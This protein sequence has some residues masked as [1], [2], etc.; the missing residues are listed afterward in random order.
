M[1]WKAVWHYQIIDFGSPVADLDR[2]LERL[3]IKVPV[4][5][6]KLRVLLDNR[7]NEECLQLARIAAR[8]RN[9]GSEN[10]MTD[11][12]V[13]GRQNVE[14][15][16]G[17]TVFSDAVNVAVSAGDEL[18]I[19]LWIQHAKRVRGLC[20]TWCARNWHSAFSRWQSTEDQGDDWITSTALIPWLRED[21][22]VPN[23]SVGLSQVE[24]LTDDTVKTIAL[25]GDSITHMS[26]YSDALAERLARDYPG[27]AVI[28]NAG[29]GG[30]RLCYDASFSPDL[31]E[32]SSVFGPAGYRRFEHDTFGLIHPDTVLMLEGVNDITHGFQYERLDQ[33]PSAEFFCERYAEVIDCAHRNG[34]RIWVGTI[35]PE[36]V[37]RS[38]DWYALSE[39]LRIEIN[40]WIRH[41]HLADG[42][43]DFA[44]IA[45]SGSGRL[46]DGF[47]LDGLH[48]N[49]AGGKEMAE[50]V[51]LELIMK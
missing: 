19:D 30:N 45:D 43:L 47:H 14:L 24:L 8:I 33:V 23:A 11:L 37:F 4:S 20:Q 36:N 6:K 10:G 13:R 44:A 9:H 16:P 28:A 34:A 32:H 27:R 5:G 2:V 26:Y 29:I 18:E 42:V 50:L 15:Q 35:M 38:E 25:F 31:K 46:K 49:E 21:V 39:K 48:P 22:H 3:I 51:P 7:K 41:Q 1:G 12:T 40:D 17:E